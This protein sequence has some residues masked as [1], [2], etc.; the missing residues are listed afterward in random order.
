MRLIYTT[1]LLVALL[2]PISADARLGM[3]DA[4]GVL[5]A[6]MIPFELPEPFFLVPRD[7]PLPPVIR[8]KSLRAAVGRLPRVKEERFAR[9]AQH[10]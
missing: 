10:P 6:A 7:L 1:S 8:A 2:V 3:P 4:L 9:G 5:H